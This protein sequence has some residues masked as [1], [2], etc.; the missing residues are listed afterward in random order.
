GAEEQRALSLDLAAGD[1]GIERRGG[2]EEIVGRRVRRV[3]GERILA[4]GGQRGSRRRSGDT[5]GGAGSRENS[6]RG[7]PIEQPPQWTREA[8]Q[9]AASGAQI[10]GSERGVQQ[11][12]DTEPAAQVER[13]LDGVALDQLAAAMLRR[14][15]RIG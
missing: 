10:G 6:S 4:Q 1:A 15:E 9:E 3:R 12:E 5:V 13:G 8:R 14:V 11:I 2:V 7:E